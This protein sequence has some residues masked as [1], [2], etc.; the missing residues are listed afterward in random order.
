MAGK[1]NLKYVDSFSAVEKV[2][3]LLEHDYN[4]VLMKLF[5][6]LFFLK[7]YFIFFNRMS[8]N[9]RTDK[10][11][12]AMAD[13]VK[14]RDGLSVDEI[15]SDLIKD[16]FCKGLRLND[17]SLIDI[18]SF[19]NET[20]CYAYGN[21][22]YG[23]HLFEKESCQEKLNKHILL[24]KYFNFQSEEAFTGVI[25][26]SL[27]QD[28]ASKYIGK[29]A[30]NIATQL[31]WTFPA[32]VDDA[33][34]SEAAHL[35]HR[36]VDAWGFVKFFFYL[37]DVELGGGPHTYVRGSHKPTFRAQLFEEKFRINRHFDAGVIKR[38]G[39]DA[40][41]PMYG[42]AGV[43][44]AA[45][46]FGLHKGESPEVMPRLMLSLVYATKD[47]GVQEFSIDPSQLESYDS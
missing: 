35:Y 19:A 6:R 21:P 16:G 2:K 23:F 34:R 18:F 30:K 37:T 40:I 38:F 36:D 39:V 25:R 24:A 27:L 45:D 31:W 29:G 28:I 12:L 1:K 14:L 33:T 8:K 15:V 42:A 46:T 11:L 22:K 32:N 5:A 7:K 41:C 9:S 3:N 4:Y 44:L 10:A 20:R 47:Y 26:S 13:G 43:G 17:K